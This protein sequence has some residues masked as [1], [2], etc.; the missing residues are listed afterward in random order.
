MD[1]HNVEQLHL[2]TLGGADALT[3]ND[4]TD[5][6]FREADLDLSAA[7]GGGDGQPDIVTL[8]GT[9]KGDHVKVRTQD[10]GVD[11]RGLAAEALVNGSET[12]DRLQIDTLDGN[13]KVD[14][15]GG[16]TSLIGVVA[17]LGAGQR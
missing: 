3:I 12:I 9:A 10:G 14:I 1:I 17:D 11:V 4:M 6:G 8:N 15:D 5:T 7:Q 13:D 2:T 16:V